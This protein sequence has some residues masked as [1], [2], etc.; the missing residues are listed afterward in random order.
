MKIT[1][2]SYHTIMIRQ[3]GPTTHLLQMKKYLRKL[4][5]EVELLDIWKSREEILKT[6]LFHIHASNIGIYDLAGYLHSLN[7]KFVVRPIFFTRHSAHTVR[8][9]CMVNTFAQHITP[10]IWSGYGITREI[11]KRTTG[12]NLVIS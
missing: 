5:V 6:D 3:A 11:C 12:R 7:A 4:G 8:M 10:A 2:A 9:A 1:L